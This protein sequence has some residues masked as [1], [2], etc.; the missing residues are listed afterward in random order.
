[1][2]SV[3]ILQGKGDMRTH[4]LIGEDPS[5]RLARIREQMLG[6]SLFSSLSSDRKYFCTFSYLCMEI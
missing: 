2:C 6:S 4:W 1:M 3:C 5:Q